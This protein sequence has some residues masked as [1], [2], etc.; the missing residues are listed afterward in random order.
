M[1]MLLFG[2]AVAGIGGGAMLSL[3]SI[4]I[5]GKQVLNDN[6]A[7][8]TLPRPCACSLYR[9]LEKLRECC[10]NHWQVFRGSNRRTD[11]RHRWLAMVR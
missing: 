4:L 9:N 11:D 5:S 7:I 8:L 1:W 2:R 3:V 6:E 10:C